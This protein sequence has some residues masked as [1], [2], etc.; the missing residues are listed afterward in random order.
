MD[1][2]ALI[3]G[4]I[5]GAFIGVLATMALRR[6]DAPRVAKAEEAAKQ[7]QHQPPVLAHQRAVHPTL[8]TRS[9]QQPSEFL[10]RLA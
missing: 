8:Y 10:T 7:L 2:V 6:G 3:S 9:E 1:P 5:V 4:L